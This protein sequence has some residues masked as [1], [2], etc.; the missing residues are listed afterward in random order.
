[1]FR[2]LPQ[3]AF[4][5][6][7]AASLGVAPPA[8]AK[9]PA[10]KPAAKATQA[11][12]AKAKRV[13]G[14]GGSVTEI[15]YALGEASR[16]VARDTSSTYPEAALKIPNV[17]Y[18]RAISAE[19]VISVSPDLVISE[20]NAG[21]PAAMDVL[22][23]A[24]IRMVSVP[25][26]TS[27]EAILQK[28]QVV[29][30]AL[31]VPKKAAELNRKVKAEL[32]AVEKAVAKHQG[33]KKRVLFILSLRGG[34][35]MAGG[36]GTSADTVLKMAGLTNAA[37][38]FQ[39]YKP[40]NDEALLAAKPDAILLMTTK[41]HSVSDAE[42]SAIPA[43]AATPAVQNKQIV[44]LD[45]LYLLGFGPRTADAVNTLHKAVYATK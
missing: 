7:L 22:K 41:N 26:E 5:L 35:V 27:A 39:G 24:S 11:K 8:E 19:S 25:G 13:V 28:I 1:M 31:G 14:L 4:S 33:P 40:M 15:I 34:R 45:G 18:V 43:L 42:F 6:F 23:S 2:H 12:A 30:D 37:S 9:K 17:G 16:L 44:R 32:E 38:G 3:L 36:E 29:G 20:A 10:A 21:P